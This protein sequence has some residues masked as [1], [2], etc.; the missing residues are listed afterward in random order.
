MEKR[1]DFL[2]YFTLAQWRHCICTRS[3]AQSLSVNFGSK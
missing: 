2:E 1:Y 3:Y